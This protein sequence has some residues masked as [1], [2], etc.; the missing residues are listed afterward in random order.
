MKKKTLAAAS[1]LLALLMPLG[2]TP[3]AVYAAGEGTTQSETS[4]V[5]E[6]SEGT[7]ET[8]KDPEK[9]DKDNTDENLEG[10]GN[11]DENSEGKDNGNTNGGSEADE[12]ESE[13]K[14]AAT[15]GVTPPSAEELGSRIWNSRSG[16]F[17]NDLELAT[18]EAQSGD[19]LYLGKGNY[20]LYG[21][22]SVGTT[23]GKDLTFVGSGVDVT[24]WNIGAPVPDP[25]K[26]GTEYNGDYSFDGA[27]TVTFENMTLRSGSADYLGFIRANN[28]VVDNC[29]IN[30]KTFYWGYKR[31]T[32]TNTTF[33]APSGDYAIWTYSSPVMTFDNC[34]FNASGKVINVY[35]DA[36]AGKNDITVNF[37][38]CTVNST[39]PI[40][41]ALN[42][43]D[44]NMGGYKYILNITNAN[45]TAAR[46]SV[47]CS[48]VFGFGGKAATNNTGRTDVNLDGELVFSA[49]KKLT[50]SYT[51]GEHDQAYN[52]TG[53]WSDWTP[54]EGDE[55]LLYRT[56]TL[57]KICKYCSYSETL[58]EEREEKREYLLHYDLNGGTGAEGVNYSDNYYFEPIG[59]NTATVAAAPSRAGYQFAGWQDAAGNQYVAGDAV[60]VDHDITLT[61][62]WN[63]LVTVS[64]DLCGH[65][66]ANISSQTFVSGNKASEPTAPKEDGWVFGGW[67]TEKGCKY[68]FSFDSAVTSD[69]I[70]YAKWDRVTTVVS[71]PVATPTPSPA[72]AATKTATVKNA[73]IP[74]TSDAFPMEDLLALLAVG[75]VGFGAAG[76]LR[77]KHH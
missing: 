31:A 75:A 66:G 20:T 56:R 8:N 58:P 36:G 28:T 70:L 46:D 19:T 61:A 2:A 67:Y 42:I 48:Q 32:F 3:L 4:N 51:D 9:K 26:Y 76:W 13:E 52:Y 60:I 22:S 21:I 57:T 5:S 16:S 47:T 34:T 73:A 45:V 35:T 17:Y 59:G 41:P 44:S 33:N 18:K 49:G 37:N 53:D 38:N 11:K 72:A 14:V 62:Q 1:L 68:R 6:G 29:T 24:A 15:N 30:G 23:K 7:G 55:H 69:I 50:H 25:D 63:K 71:A 12:P 39:F 74:Q 10:N 77:K 40:K 27:G 65:G 43:N 64:F 54:T